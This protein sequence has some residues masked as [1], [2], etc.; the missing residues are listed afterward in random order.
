MGIPQ[1]I[2]PKYS[3]LPIQMEMFV[4]IPVELLPIIPTLTFITLPPSI[5]P[6]DTV[7]LHALPSV[8][9]PLQP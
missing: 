2:H 1:E 9:V 6:I 4:V 3:E 5:F 7:W 8:V